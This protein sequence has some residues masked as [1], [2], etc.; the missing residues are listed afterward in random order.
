VPFPKDHRPFKEV[1]VFGHKR[2]RFQG[3]LD[4]HDWPSWETVQ[5]PE[6]FRYQIPPSAGPRLFAKV[7]P[8]EPELQRMLAQS[9][10][11]SHLTPPSCL[12][13][14]SPPLTLGLGHVALLL[15]SGHLDG[16]VQPEGK[17]PHVVRGSSRKHSFVSDVSET[18][19]PDGSTTTRTTISERTEL[20][21]RTVDLTGHIQTY[22]QTGAEPG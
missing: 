7:Q 19:N 8:T 6:D 17:Q 9:P 14:P 15:A 5:A 21:V 2:A 10:L 4:D 11:R 20:V 22:S 1:I 12:P 18:G 3:N 16:I 13:L